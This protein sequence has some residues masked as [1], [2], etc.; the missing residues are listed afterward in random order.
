VAPVSLLAVSIAEKRFPAVAEAEPRLVLKDLAF[1]VSEGQFVCL[2]GPS[3]CGKTTTLNIIAGLDNDYVGTLR[4]PTG[5][6]R[7][8]Y[9]FQSP[10]LLPWRT[11]LENVTLVVPAGERQDNTSEALLRDVGLWESRHFYP[12]RL[13]L[14]MQRRVALARAYAVSPDI[15]LMDEPF[16]SLDEATA[17]HLRRL[18][19]DLWQRRPTT[20]LF[21]THDLREAVTLAD[22]LLIYSPCPARVI[23]DMAIA[24]PRAERSDP[25][26]IDALRRTILD[27]YESTFTG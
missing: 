23:G 19:V 5:R 21:V 8:G 3:G 25:D 12:P 4:L 1:D 6:A 22:R 10:R 9:V 2:T 13:S 14:G 7:I 17:Q 24:L 11:V 18:L 27:K 15:L 26:R 16:A 20:V